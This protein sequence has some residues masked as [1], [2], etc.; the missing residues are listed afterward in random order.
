MA[1]ARWVNRSDPLKLNDLDVRDD[2]SPERMHATR[3]GSQNESTT[4]HRLL[5][6]T[7]FDSGWWHV[8]QYLRKESIMAT[9]N[10]LVGSSLTVEGEWIEIKH[11]HWANMNGRRSLRLHVSDVVG[12]EVHPPRWLSAGQVTVITNGTF[13]KDTGRVGEQFTDGF[14]NPLMVSYTKNEQAALDEVVAAFEA[15][16]SRS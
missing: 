5:S 15:A 13:R 8:A 7:R 16:K 12:F 10:G 1:T 14:K 2:G 9:L 3:L 11:D 6:L 4:T